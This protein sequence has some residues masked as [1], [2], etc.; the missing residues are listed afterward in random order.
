MKSILAIVS[1]AAFAVPFLG[2]SPS[3]QAEEIIYQASGHKN[4]YQSAANAIVVPT[5]AKVSVP[6]RIQ[7]DANVYRSEG[8]A[9]AR[10][11]HMTNVLSL[12]VNCSDPTT[13]YMG[14]ALAN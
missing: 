11:E 7:H 14:H 5:P 8:R 6:V 13:I 3:S 9:T 10:E 2:F 1:A 12:F 4:I